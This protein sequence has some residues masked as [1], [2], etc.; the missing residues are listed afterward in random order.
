MTR[1]EGKQY[2]RQWALQV[3]YVQEPVISSA[4]SLVM[5]SKMYLQQDKTIYS[6]LR[7]NR[8][9]TKWMRLQMKTPDEAGG[10]TCVHCGR[11]GLLPWTENVKQKAVLDHILEI[12]EGGSW[13]DPI[14]FQVSC[15][16]CNNIKDRMRRRRKPRLV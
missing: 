3:V 8:I 14:N 7:M 2:R 15:D 10:L 16:R 6:E 1:S 13:N 11:K 9:R 4:A 5:L 12:S